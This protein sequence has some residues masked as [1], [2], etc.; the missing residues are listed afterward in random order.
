MTTY[1]TQGP[2]SPDIWACIC[3]EGNPFGLG[4]RETKRIP[5]CFEAHSDA[6]LF[7]DSGKKKGTLF[8]E[9]HV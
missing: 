9:D 3:V 1:L 4:Q 7:S 8:G 5:I 6:Q 2:H